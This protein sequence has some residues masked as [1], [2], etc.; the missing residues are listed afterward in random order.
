MKKQKSYWQKARLNLTIS[1]V[2]PKSATKEHLAIHKV[3]ETLVFLLSLHYVTEMM[4][5]GIPEV[6]H[7][8]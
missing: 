3:Y 7:H 6:F 2:L 5:G 4:H 1:Q 8:L